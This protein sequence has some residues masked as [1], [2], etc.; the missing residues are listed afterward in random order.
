LPV[1][2][3]YR[4]IRAFLTELSAEIPALALEN[5]QFSRQNVSDAAVEAR[6][7]LALYLEQSS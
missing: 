5:V 4:Q 2:G 1:T 3:E 6:I 7:R